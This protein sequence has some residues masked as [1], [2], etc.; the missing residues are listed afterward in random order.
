MTEESIYE[1]DYELRHIC[2]ICEMFMPI[3]QTIRRKVNDT[4]KEFSLCGNCGTEIMELMELHK[5]EI[6]KK[7]ED[8]N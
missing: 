6:K 2:Y 7:T 1:G 3:K 5:K 4:I 8:K